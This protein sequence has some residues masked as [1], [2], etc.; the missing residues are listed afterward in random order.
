MAEIKID[1]EAMAQQMKDYC[2]LGVLK[3]LSPDKRTAD[4]TVEAMEVYIRHGVSVETALKIITEL[5]PIFNKY[6]EKK[7]TDQ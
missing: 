3:A 4:M 5:Q 1:L 7:E 2:A 6:S